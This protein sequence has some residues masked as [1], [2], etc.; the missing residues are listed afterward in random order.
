MRR[1]LGIVGLAVLLS[2]FMATFEPAV[3]PGHSPGAVTVRATGCWTYACDGTDPSSTGCS[4]SYASTV[5]AVSIADEIHYP[6]QSGEVDNRWSDGCYTNWTRAL[7]Y[8]Y[9]TGLLADIY[10]D[11][12]DNSGTQH[13]YSAAGTSTDI[14][15]AQIY[16]PDWQTLSAGGFNNGGGIYCCNNTGWAGPVDACDGANQ[17][18]WP[19][20]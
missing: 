17:W 9:S 2:L 7:A 15:T 5:V 10:S 18:G 1:Q 11:A 19:Q 3:L 16:A 20:G 12:C 6:N 13:H 4:S 14:W 8:S